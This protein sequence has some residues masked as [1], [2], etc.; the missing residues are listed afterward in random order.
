MD[1]TSSDLLDKIANGEHTQAKDVFSALM[2]DRVL[3]ELGAKKMEIAAS[4][5]PSSEQPQSEIVLDK[6]KE[7]SQE[8]EN[9]DS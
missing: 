7:I 9:E 5:L 6:A 2:N 8:D 1:Y 3:S 4:L